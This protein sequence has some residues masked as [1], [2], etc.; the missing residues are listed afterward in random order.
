MQPEGRHLSMHILLVGL[1]HKTAPLQV[2]ESVAFPKEQ[3]AEA[4][5]A[6][7]SRVGE[8]V[9]L[10]TCNRTEVYSVSDEPAAALQQVK[11]FLA[12]FHGLRTEDLA[13]HLYDYIDGEAVRHLFRVAGG[14]DSMIVG[15][16]QIL[17]QVRD[18][19]AAATEHESAELPLV[20][21]F[22]A[23]VR[24]G[25]RVREETDVGRNALSVSYAGV[26]L[27]Q[28]VLG[29][30]RPLKVLLI[31]AGEAGRLVASALRTVGVGDLVVSN[32]TKERAYELSES[33]GAR[34]AP[35]S[36]IPAALADAD[37]VIAA[38]DSPGFIVTPDMV[39]NSGRV[40]PQ[41]FFDLAMPR[42]VDPR[43]GELKG[44]T[45]FNIDGLASIAEE[46]LEERHR[47]ATDAEA[48][49]DEEV[50]RF[51]RWWDGLDAVPV[52]KTLQQQAEQI[53][54]RE[55]ERALRRLTDISAN[56][57]EVVEALTRSIVKK[58]LHQPTKYLRQDADKS[59]LQAL[60][61]LFRMGDDR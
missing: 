60:G 28:R 20:G 14:L 43:V 30:L 34:V 61:E 35:F 41:F 7:K 10:S 33:L 59:Q 9:I 15:E 24:A 27:A 19:L 8:G 50:A 51:L 22:H 31:G 26:R 42:D 58:L 37:I 55:L 21:L 52:I 54:K 6:L 25:R 11:V 1:N 16:S 3:L 32:R 48:I 36:E 44:T 12:E 49:V 45:L 17:G 47:A 39:S 5:P 13:P 46:N 56:D 29:D 40:Q 23:G 57:R 38:T 4:L 53:R 18:S 2:R